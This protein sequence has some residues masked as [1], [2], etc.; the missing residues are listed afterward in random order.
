[1]SA[2]KTPL[3]RPIHASGAYKA[4]N[5]LKWRLL[6]VRRAPLGR[7]PAPIFRTG[8]SRAAP[9]AI[10]SSP[11]PQGAIFFPRTLRG[12][13]RGR[14]PDA[15]WRLFPKTAPSGAH[16]QKT[17]AQKRPFLLS[18]PQ[19]RPFRFLGVFL[20]HRAPFGRPR[21]PFRHP[22]AP[23]S[24]TDAATQPPDAPPAPPSALGA[25][26]A[27]LA[28]F[29]DQNLPSVPLIDGT[30]PDLPVLDALNENSYR[31]P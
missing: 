23:F 11:A 28:R 12:V 18:A 8:A 26:Q 24:F 9:G 22:R 16:L 15:P 21:P 20:R 13:P 25:P 19:R 4:P 5:Q 17:T 29:L 1:M 3:G 31:P 14:S 2:P 6:S 30:I 7:P 27:D 10:F